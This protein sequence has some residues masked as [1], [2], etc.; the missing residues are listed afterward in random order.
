MGNDIE[1]TGAAAS[2]T[3]AP[4]RARRSVT[5]A[6]VDPDA[7]LRS[8]HDYWC[9]ADLHKA[10]KGTKAEGPCDCHMRRIRELLD[11][12]ERY[13]KALKTIEYWGR[14]DIANS[15][16]D[17]RHRMW[18]A[19]QT[20]LLVAGLAEPRADAGQLVIDKAVAFMDHLCAYNDFHHRVVHHAALELSGAVSDYLTSAARKP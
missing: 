3:D 6:D 20:A 8:Q 4:S 17:V 7:Q 12:V 5:M 11:V 10:L 16:S 13:E 1:A 15:P 9:A 2:A 14:A 19:A 18:K